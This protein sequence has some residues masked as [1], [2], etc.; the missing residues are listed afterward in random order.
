MTLG[1][2]ILKIIR[3][4]IEECWNWKIVQD[5]TENGWLIIIRTQDMVK[6]NRFGRTDH[7]MKDIGRII[8]RMEKEG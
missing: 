6:E 3:W 2:M 8:K 5:M 4:S 1:L 7:Y